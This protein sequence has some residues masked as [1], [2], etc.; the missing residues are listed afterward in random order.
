MGE[1]QKA[2]ADDENKQLT[3][4]GP[5]STVIQYRLSHAPNFQ[6]L[7]YINTPIG[8]LHAKFGVCTSAQEHT[9]CVVGLLKQRQFTSV[10]SVIFGRQC[11]YG[12]I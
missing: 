11:V 2:N 12:F 9:L 6:E 3:L 4:V 8:L 1:V 5:P 7:S 10:G